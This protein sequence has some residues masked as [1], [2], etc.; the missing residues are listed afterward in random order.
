MEITKKYFKKVNK[1]VSSF[2]KIAVDN[3]KADHNKI[4]ADTI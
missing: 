3:L 4:Q 2:I 1:K